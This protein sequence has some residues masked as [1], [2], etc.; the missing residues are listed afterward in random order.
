MNV[1]V[2]KIFNIQVIGLLIILAVL[3]A[4]RGKPD[5]DNT[6]IENTDFS[7]SVRTS[8]SVDADESGW[9]ESDMVTV[10]GEPLRLE[11]VGDVD[12]CAN[13]IVD[14]TVNI[15]G[16]DVQSGWHEVLK[17]DG[18]PFEIPVGNTFTITTNG[19]WTAWYPWNNPSGCG[20]PTCTPTGG[21]QYFY[22]GRRVYARLASDWEFIQIGGSGGNND[23][24]DIPVQPGDPNWDMVVPSLMGINPGDSQRDQLLDSSRSD[25][26]T[27][28]PASR[29]FELFGS[30][31][32]TFTFT[33]GNIDEATMAWHGYTMSDY[34]SI[35]PP[36][37]VSTSKKLWLRLSDVGMFADNDGDLEMYIRYDDNCP[38][39]N[40]NFLEACVG[41]DA[42]SCTVI[43]L[44]NEAPNGSYDDVAPNSGKIFFRIVDTTA[45]RWNGEVRGDADY[46][47]CDT[48]D[49]TLICNEGS[50]KVTYA[51]DQTGFVDIINAMIGP[52]K[53]FLQGEMQPDGK[54]DG[55]LTKDVYEALT[56]DVGFINFLRALLV[57]SVVLYGFTYM[58]GLARITSKELFEYAFKMMLIIML[59]SEN[60]WEFFYEY[61][62]TV[63]IEG[64]ENL[65]EIVSGNFLSLTNDSAL[66]LGAGADNPTVETTEGG[67]VFTFD[68]LNQT[69][70][71]YFSE[72]AA[73][74]IEALLF[75]SLLGFFLAML[76]YAGIFI[77]VVAMLKAVILY[78][79]SV[80]MVSLMLFMAPI[81]FAFLLFS[82][83]RD[84]F[85][86]WIR[87]LISYAIQPL[88]LFTVLAIF[89]I[90]IFSAFYRVLNFHVCWG[91]LFSL[92]FPINEVIFFNLIYDFDKFCVLEGY[93][94]WSIN[95]G[96]EPDA[97]FSKNPVA[98]F[99][100]FIFIIFC[101]AMLKFT[102]WVQQIAGTIIGGNTT[103]SLDKAASAAINEGTNFGKG[104]YNLAKHTGKAGFGAVDWGME[105]IAGER[106]SDKYIKA[107]RQAL[108]AMGGRSRAF[109]KLAAGG[110]DKDM[111]TTM[112]WKESLMTSREKRAL[113]SDRQAFGRLSESQKRAQYDENKQKTAIYES[114]KAEA[115]QKG[116]EVGNK[117]KI[118]IRAERKNYRSSMAKALG[119]GKIGE[120]IRI[121]KKKNEK[122]GKMQREAFKEQ[123]KD[124]SK[125]KVAEGRRAR[126]KE[127]REA[128]K[129]QIPKERTVYGVQKDAEIRKRKNKGEGGQYRELS[130]LG[131]IAK[132]GANIA[133]GTAKTAYNVVR[134]P[135][136][137]ARATY[138]AGKN[139][140]GVLYNEASRNIKSIYGTG[141]KGYNK[142]RNI[143]RKK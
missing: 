47:T 76:I 118:A 139:V 60:S 46:T 43:D 52:I 130:V 29:T 42:G 67:Q 35:S 64:T 104:T 119:K 44:H 4:C 112:R 120:A 79:I 133:T 92:D 57:L 80:I 135:D 96:M 116:F 90:F 85:D 14:T 110:Q 121:N 59:I 56:D 115:K 38:G 103:T 12:L 132:V 9:T 30:G 84:L 37:P 13:R 32:N 75:S 107:K 106:L 53:E 33:P 128:Q 39:R 40:G 6:C 25:F 138:K 15:N 124:I 7:T 58:L 99:L 125:G 88:M 68:F 18:T 65:I 55:G 36:P 71:R 2:K 50:Y 72:D 23:E 66:D 137:A 24:D 78:I 131:G 69:M 22:D 73:I 127:M 108:R 141:K 17:T 129:T 140:A 19:W 82:L 122:I 34:L 16:V 48:S 136:R 134:A 1:A 102:T 114:K 142:I 143:F 87:N 105:R 27:A 49:P 62:F 94:P 21:R 109:G 101:S 123:L 89:N 54:R 51:L 26:T 31:S 98:L 91:C 97:E 3:S 95:G 74:R 5:A 11:I 10:A 86:N 20:H 113:A 41:A 8:V 70:Q 28:T 111:G 126:W 100:A 77:F 61:L 93:R 117:R 83:T 81:F 63:F 45:P